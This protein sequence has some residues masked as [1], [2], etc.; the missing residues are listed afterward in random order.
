[1]YLCT[2]CEINKLKGQEGRHR[3][4]CLRCGRGDLPAVPASLAVAPSS[5]GRGGGR[6]SLLSR[7]WDGGPACWTST[8]AFLWRSLFYFFKCFVTRLIQ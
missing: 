7:P 8:L 3:G 2:T 1:M 4:E 6:Q 5:R